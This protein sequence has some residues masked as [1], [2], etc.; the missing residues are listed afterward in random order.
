MQNVAAWAEWQFGKAQLG[1]V[2]RTR[3]LVLMAGDVARRP[4]GIVSRSCESSAA[5][6]G[7]F[8]FLE[9]SAISADWIREPAF[10]RTVEECSTQPH[11]I[12]ALDGSAL[13][14]KDAYGRKGLGGVGAW[15]QHGRGV[16]TMNALA[17]AP[18][19]RTIGLCGQQ[20]WIRTSPSTCKPHEGPT[21]RSESRYWL[22]LIEEVDDRF[23][24]AE[25][26][27]RPWFQMDRGADLWPVFQLAIDRNAWVTVRAVHDRSLE[28]GGRLWA[29]LE[30]SKPVA[31][32]RVNVPARPP[33]RRRKRVKGKRVSSFSPPRKARLARIEIR[34]ATVGLMCKTDGSKRTPVPI[35]AVLVSESGRGEDR[36]EWMLLTTHPIETRADVLAVVHAY[37]LRW[38]V[39]DFHR[40]WKSGLCSVEDTQ[41]RSRDAILKWATILAIVATRAMRLTQ[42]ARQTPDALATTE[43]SEHELQAIVALRRP[44]NFD[45][46]NLK[47]LTINQAV[48]WIADFSGYSGPWKGPPGVTIVGRGLRDVLVTASA[49]AYRDEN[50]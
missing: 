12:V 38:R 37:T 31:K 30:A 23:A 34:A 16:Q 20:T 4:S 42:L 19:G 40:T 6:E 41:L 49:F 5:R 44:K 27:V 9:N 24:A 33:K 13:S 47:Q 50:R 15:S 29:T 18:D 32:R 46:A 14:M 8:R 35:N 26:P 25:T 3:R 21:S 22:E 1:D 28:S 36:I 43:F 48:R 2:R 10:H 11:V 39:E 17:V 45:G 7:A